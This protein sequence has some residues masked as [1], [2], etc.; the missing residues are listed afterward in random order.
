MGGS[1]SVSAQ[2][3]RISSQDPSD[4]GLTSEGK[5]TNSSWSIEEH[6]S[7]VSSD[8]PH[9]TT[10]AA[11]TETTFQRT[12]SVAAC[13]DPSSDG[14]LSPGGDDGLEYHK[15]TA[16]NST[17]L[18]FKCKEGFG[19]IGKATIECVNGEWVGNVPIC[20][21][22]KRHQN[23]TQETP[24]QLDGS[25]PTQ[26]QPQGIPYTET[27]NVDNLIY[28]VVGCIF[29]V[30]ALLTTVI[31]FI[32]MALLRR[33]KKKKEDK[34]E[35]V[36]NDSV[37]S[38]DGDETSSTTPIGDPANPARRN[39]YNVL[40]KGSFYEV[41][42]LDKLENQNGNLVSNRHRPSWQWTG[43]LESSTS[44]TDPGNHL[45]LERKFSRVYDTDV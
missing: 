26:A 40:S 11:R 39:S 24:L 1:V 32:L 35:D 45:K 13:N 41:L 20:E 43:G 38:L 28:A 17:T 14:T 44:W 23:S 7:I 5:L 12:T 27:K 4:P 36:D 37:K 8:Y 34:E 10:A 3:P 22:K 2:T 31:G 42:D 15:F 30:V 9:A 6:T 33:R 19:M 29:G 18:V 16:E 21:N 25:L